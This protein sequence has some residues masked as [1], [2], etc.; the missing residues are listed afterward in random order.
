MFTSVQFKWL[1]K[2][3]DNIDNYV[4]SKSQRL[5]NFSK[6]TSSL[7]RFYEMHYSYHTPNAQSV[8]YIYVA[9]KLWVT[10]RSNN[11]RSLNR[12]SQDSREKKSVGNHSTST[13]ICRKNDT[14]IFWVL[15]TVL[16]HRWTHNRMCKNM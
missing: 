10:D 8:L 1:L 15:N 16:S 12:K 13:L 11:K 3:L 6:V 14:L 4:I 9:P 5:I 7:Q 2:T